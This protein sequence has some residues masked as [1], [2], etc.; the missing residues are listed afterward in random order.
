MLLSLKVPTSGLQGSGGYK[1][2]EVFIRG[3][4]GLT[5]MWEFPK[6]GD[7]NIVP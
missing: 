2:L 4:S 1:M 3:F 5:L 6:I 7:P